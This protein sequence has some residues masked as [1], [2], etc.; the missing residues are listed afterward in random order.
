MAPG[1]AAAALPESAQYP[2]T[3]GAPRG[4]TS[5]SAGGG[6]EAAAAFTAA[7]AASTF[8]V[9]VQQRKPLVQRNLELL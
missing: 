5:A 9:A 1:A 2:A 7:A 8:P 3:M 4:P 6:A